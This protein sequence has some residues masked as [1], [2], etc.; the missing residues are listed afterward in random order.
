M[1]FTR[2]QTIEGYLSPKRILMIYGPRRIGKTTM[3][4]KYLET[5][6]KDKNVR[7][8]VGEDLDLREILNSQRR[9]QILDFAR[10]FDV[11]VID[12]A[13][14]IPLIGL[15]GKM[16]IDEFPEKILV[17]TGS[18]SFELSQQVGEPLVGRQFRMTL[19]PI[20]QIEISG[21]IFDKKQQL[22]NTLLYGSYPEVLLVDDYTKK[23][24]TLK[25]L[26]SSYLFKDI[27]SLDKIKS[28]DLLL[29]IT[30]ALALQIGSE[31]SI[32]KLTKD[33]GEN[34]HKKIAR[35]LDLLEKTFIIKKV[36]AFS[37]NLRNEISKKVK[38]Y[39]YDLGIRNA[40]IGQFNK[41]DSRNDVGAL[42]ENFVFMELYKKF[43]MKN[44][45]FE[46]MYFWRNKEKREVDI[47]I[48]EG[49]KIYAYECKWS[50][51]EVVFT[52]FKKLYP[53][54]ITNVISKENFTDFF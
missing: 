40:V 45:Y 29:N 31:V 49:D 4:K 46:G 20:A 47:V 37:N 6:P 43:K 22:E 17:F 13:Q 23:E 15:A 39:F 35:Y 52:D 2:K 34:D 44:D 42:W 14:K 36:G 33:V 54:A 38:Y 27:L 51:K 11:I 26:V 24:Y 48:E 3:V 28:P 25:E 9:A 8:A 32:T 1:N 50:P 21:N 41:L 10:P 7:Y 18:S 30:R 5:V 19:L 12:E 16:I 53:N